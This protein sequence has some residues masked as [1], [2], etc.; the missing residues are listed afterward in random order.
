MSSS[1]IEKATVTQDFRYRLALRA[2]Q[3]GGPAGAG[4]EVSCR[5]CGSLN[6]GKGIA[7][8]VNIDAP[9]RSQPIRESCAAVVLR[10]DNM[11]HRLF[12]FDH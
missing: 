1:V 2:G 11:G 7:G 12:R 3:D 6:M 9:C 10:P 5:E 8:R 4:L